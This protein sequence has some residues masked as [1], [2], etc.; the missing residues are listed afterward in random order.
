MIAKKLLEAFFG[1]GMTKHLLERFERQRNDVRAGL[2][3]FDHVPRAAA[4]GGEDLRL[5]IVVSI[6][7]KDVLNHLYARESKVIDPAHERA[8]DVGPR[9]GRHQRLGRAEAQ[10][11][12]DTDAFLRQRVN[13][14][15]T[16]RNQ[17]DFDDYVLVNF[18]EAPPFRN[19]FFRGQREH[20]SAHIAV[21]QLADLADL[22]LYGNTFFSDQARIGGNAINNPP[23]RGGAQF[24]QVG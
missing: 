15:D 4:G 11:H 23:S 10:C 7:G 20:F 6:D 12:I 16:F 19:H 24:L 3:Y 17:R 1:Q 13:R 18:G 14:L 5:E 8:H 2:G 9:F 22:F 21:D